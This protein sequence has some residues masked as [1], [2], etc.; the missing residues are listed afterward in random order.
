MTSVLRPLTE[1]IMM[2]VV[3]RRVKALLFSEDTSPLSLNFQC[4]LAA[5]YNS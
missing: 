4:F 3:R 1:V 2:D 5:S